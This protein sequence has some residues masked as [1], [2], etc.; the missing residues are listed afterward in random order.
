MLC[1]YPR[2][3]KKKKQTDPQ[4]IHSGFLP[5]PLGLIGISKEPLK[6]QTCDVR[7]SLTSHVFLFSPRVQVQLCLPLGGSLWEGVDI[8]GPDEAAVCAQCTPVQCGSLPPFPICL[9]LCLAVALGKNSL[10][11]VMS[12]ACLQQLHLT[13]FI[14]VH[15][16]SWPG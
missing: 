9:L 14:F 16:C 1:F 10:W 15:A 4:P 7:V 2:K 6:A 8:I 12:W 5:Q 11:G 3:K 13:C